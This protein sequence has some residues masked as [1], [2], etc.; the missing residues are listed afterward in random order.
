MEELSFKM[1]VTGLYSKLPIENTTDL[2]NWDAFIL[3]TH[4]DYG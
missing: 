2:L 4:K 3:K 1:E